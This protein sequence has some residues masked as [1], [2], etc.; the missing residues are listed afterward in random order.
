MDYPTHGVQKPHGSLLWGITIV[1]ACALHAQ[2]PDLNLIPWPITVLSN[3]AGNAPVVASTRIVV[4]SAQILP[5]ARI[6]SQEINA[7]T[8]IAPSTVQGQALSD[9]I[10]L[11]LQPE[12]K[13]EEER[14]S[15]DSAGIRIAGKNYA[16][17]AMATATLLQLINNKNGSCQVPY[18]SIADAPFASY[19]GLMIDVARQWHTIETLKKIVYVCRLY[20]IKYLHLHLCDDQLFTFQSSIC[21]SLA[22]PGK[23]YSAAQLRDLE[24]YA[25]G[26]GV[27]IIPEL[28]MPGHA[29]Q[30]VTRVP[31]IFKIANTSLASTL[32]F[33]SPEARN[34]LAAIITEACSIFTA[35]PYFHMGGDECDWTGA[36]QNVDFKNLMQQ[37]GYTDAYDVYVDFI[38]AMD[39]VVKRNN[40]RLIVWEGFRNDGSPRVKV[41]KDVTVMEFEDLYNLPDNLINYGY[42]VINTCWTPLY[43]IPWRNE[44]NF[45]SSTVY[46]WNLYTFGS[47]STDYSKTTWHTIDPSPLVI[48]A[49][50]CAWE[51]NETA[52]IPSFRKKVPAMSERIWNPNAG[53]TYAD[54]E[55]R[56]S[57]TD[58]ILT[59]LMQQPQTNAGPQPA[60][61]ADGRCYSISQDNRGNVLVRAPAGEPVSVDVFDLSG[62]FLRG[63][64][65]GAP[66]TGAQVIRVPPGAIPAGLY[67][68]RLRGSGSAEIIR[69]VRVT[70]FRQ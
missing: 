39:S 28:D 13:E 22:T 44:Q 32:N 25:V 52:E 16:S 21:P 40:K 20:K 66:V 42:T 50:F 59:K 15:V 27:T 63:L 53:K 3:G 60:A 37:K 56:F 51:Q 45:P 57:A 64:Y 38:A 55:R 65:S 35:T 5:L 24:N 1:V 54:F 11:T 7:L 47:Y 48:G 31:A 23:S 43:A 9:D 36:E 4:D 18:V 49:Q 17:L 6:L 8:G 10:S 61:T 46:N 2:T 30:F 26:H 14:V 12:L 68:F 29:T 69:H 67:L 58:S 41:P 34:T 70:C 33:A 19:R 62:R